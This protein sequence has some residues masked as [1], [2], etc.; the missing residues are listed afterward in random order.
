VPLKLSSN[1]TMVPHAHEKFF[2]NLVAASGMSAGDKAE[3]DKFFDLLMPDQADFFYV[4]LSEDES[5]LPRILANYR[6]KCAA[7]RERDDRMLEEILKTEVA[8]FGT[9]G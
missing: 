3:L 8:D 2:R 4:L 5:W 1:L 6:A 9:A 7:F